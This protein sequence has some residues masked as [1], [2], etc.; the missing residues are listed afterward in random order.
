M[1]REVQADMAE[2][3]KAVEAEAAEQIAKEPVYQAMRWLKKGEMTTAEGEEIKVTDG[4]KLDAAA[5]NAIFPSPCPA[6]LTWPSSGHDAQDRRHGPQ[7]SWPRCSASVTPP[8]SSRRSWRRSPQADQ[9]QGLTDQMMLERYGDAATP[10]GMERA[11][12][13][14]VHNENRAVRWPP[15][16]QP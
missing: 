16:W 1:L 10:R 15:R 9:V 12:D 5:V 8:T 3:R 6:G 7:A 11:A 14:A 4:F 13:E 2:K